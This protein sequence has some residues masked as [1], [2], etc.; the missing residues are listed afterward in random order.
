[1]I[2][3]NWNQGFIQKVI[4][5][6]GFYYSFSRIFY[7]RDFLIFFNSFLVYIKYIVMYYV[8]SEMV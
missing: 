1:M 7:E 4:Y 3:F 5:L 8:I 6:W 2:V